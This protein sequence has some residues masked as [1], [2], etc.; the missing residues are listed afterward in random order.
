MKKRFSDGIKKIR[1]TQGQTKT[2]VLQPTVLVLA[3]YILMLLSKLIDFAFI[4]RENEYFSIV[5]LQMMIFLLPGALW[6]KF[7]GERYTQKLRIKL[8]AFNTVPLM[9]A[10]ALALISGG[11]LISVLFG[12]LDS[13]SHNFSLYDTFISKDNGTVGSRLYLLLAFAVL[14]A[15]CEEF[16]FRGILTCEYERGGVTRSVVLSS[17]FFALL[18]FNIVNIPVYLFAGAVLAL[19]LY[20]TRSLIG[21]MIVHFLYNLFGLFAQP[22]MSALYNITGSPEFFVFLTAVLFFVSA[23]VFCGQASKLYRQYLYHGDSAA[24]RQPVIK[25]KQDIKRSYID[26]IR[27]PS[28][29]ACAVIYV[30]ALIISWL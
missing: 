11:V 29:I 15:I 13:L 12:G 6:C 25:K 28:A 5:M 10:A 9:L 4:N 3:T 30:L 8:P 19:T 27:A 24:Y 1:D 16:V 22:Y 20:A 21:A 26:V 18:H 7:S 17:V 23:A 2:V 14:P